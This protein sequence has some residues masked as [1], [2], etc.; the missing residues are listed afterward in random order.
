MA[1]PS[2]FFRSWIPWA[3]LLG[4]ALLVFLGDAFRAFEAQELSF[5]D[6]RF[7]LRGE[8]SPHPDIVIVEIND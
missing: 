5:L 2:A 4:F 6:P 7:R 8:R 1:R 3:V